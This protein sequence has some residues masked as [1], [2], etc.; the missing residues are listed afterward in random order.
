METEIQESSTFRDEKRQV[1]RC[2]N[3][4]LKLLQ[5]L[6][7]FPPSPSGLSHLQQNFSSLRRKT[8]C[9]QNTGAVRGGPDN[10]RNLGPPSR[11]CEEG[12]TVRGCSLK[13]R[14]TQW[15]RC[16]CF[17]VCLTQCGHHGGDTLEVV[18]RSA[19]WILKCYEWEESEPGVK[20]VHQEKCTKSPL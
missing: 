9:G 5:N 13:G 7:S 3:E 17:S 20:A 14:R 2:K 19:L 11:P 18:S 12:D 8:Q 10:C 6:P 4:P 1:E 16:V 15:G